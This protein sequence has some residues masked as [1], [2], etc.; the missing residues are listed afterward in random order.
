MTC[1]F[2][3]RIF[4]PN[5]KKIRAHKD[6]DFLH[7]A[8]SEETCRSLS[9]HHGDNIAECA[10][11]ISRQEN[12]IYMSIYVFRLELLERECWVIMMLFDH[13]V[14]EILR[15][16]LNLLWNAVKSEMRN[17]HLDIGEI[18]LAI[19]QNLADFL[20]VLGE[21]V[22]LFSVFGESLRHLFNSFSMGEVDVEGSEVLPR[23]VAAREMLPAASDVVDCFGI[24]DS[25][26]HHD[27]YLLSL[28]IISS[29]R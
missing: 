22:Q 9:F 13:Q 23:F 12:V 3:E 8:D 4:T 27:V 19:E 2:W 24:I 6:P 14:Y 29:L 15:K 18:H 20:S 7:H 1:C 11:H 28:F 26:I 17:F 5:Y 10:E 16:I 25:K 21:E